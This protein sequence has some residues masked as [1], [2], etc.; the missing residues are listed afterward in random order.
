MVVPDSGANVGFLFLTEC[1]RLR[2]GEMR[3]R[4][5]RPIE[6]RLDEL[7][8]RRH[9]D[10]G[11]DID[12]YALWPLFATGAAVPAR[13]GRCIFVPLLGHAYSSLSLRA[14]RGRHR[15]NIKWEISL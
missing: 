6:I 13:G 9:R 1:P 14:W 12:G 3:Q 4:Y 7:R 5:R 8:R 2:I 10:M 11:M 15:L